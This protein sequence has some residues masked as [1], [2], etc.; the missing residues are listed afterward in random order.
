MSTLTEMKELLDLGTK[1]GLTDEAL[2]QFVHDE[3][4]RMRDEREK[5]RSER[6]ADK[7]REFQLQL[8]KERSDRARAEH[9]YLLELEEKKEQYAISEHKRRMDEIETDHQFQELASERS[10]RATLESTHVVETRL[11]VKGPKL[12]AF[13]ETKDN[14]D[15]YI[16]RFERYATAQ[17]WNTRN[18]GSHLSAL[19][20]GKALDV[21]ARLPP[22]SALDFDELKEALYKRF[23]MTED[24][25]RKKFRNSKP[26]GSETFVQFSSRI[27]NYIER[28][29][30]LSKTEKTY[31][32]LKDLFLREQFMMCCSKELQ[33]FLRERTPSTITDMAKIADQFAEARATTS[34]S[35]TQKYFGSEKK[36]PHERQAKEKDRFLQK[37]ACYS[38]GK[39]GH[40]AVDC[41]D[42][43]G[44]DDMSVVNSKQVRFHDDKRRNSQQNARERNSGAAKQTYT[45]ERERGSTNQWQ[46]RNRQG[47]S[48][49]EVQKY[50]NEPVTRIETVMPVVKGCVGDRI[51]NVLRDTGCGGAVIRKDLVKEEQMTGTIQR[52]V[53]ADGSVVEADVAEV[54]VDTPYYSGAIVAW[55]F[56][57]PSYD[58]ILGNIDGVRRADD[59]DTSWIMAKGITTAVHTRSQ[60]KKQQSRYKPLRVPEALTDVSPEEIIREQQTDPTLEKLRNLAEKKSIKSYSDGGK[61]NIYVQNEM[62]YREFSSPK[63][64]NGK[65]FVNLLYPRNTDPQ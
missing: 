27:N 20:T 43:K 57:N 24:G 41:N 7:E 2:K 1:M 35:L 65:H 52:C 18:W 40:K 58:L 63:I 26:D 3:Q 56:D 37:G 19:L 9:Q 23:E 44:K 59:P 4:N 8:E 54:D 60:V 50:F 33:L 61:T 49:V 42:N 39:Y 48:V 30:E 10:Q 46:G 12:P 13:D 25:F 62:L 34:S 22:T 47:S 21:F 17:Q 15:A 5:E 45:T 14:I 36:S 11:P 28:W 55:C 32:K 64:S 31:D 38:C 16:Q 51:V 29:I 53:L 6:Q